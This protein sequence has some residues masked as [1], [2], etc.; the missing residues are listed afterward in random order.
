L[1]VDA[2]LVNALREQL[3]RRAAHASR[4]GWKV[5]AGDSE[6][7]GGELAVG[8]L[9]SATVLEPGSA[10]RGGG[11]DLHADAEVAL[12]LGDGERVSGYGVA[13]ELVDLDQGDDAEGIVAANIFHRAVAFGA[14]REEP[15]RGIHAAVLVNGETRG[16]APVPEDV[17]RRVAAVSR[18]LAAVGEELR[19][20]DRI[21]T[22]S[23]VQVPVRSGDEV[24]A[25]MGALGRVK[26][27]VA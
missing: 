1:S 8:H 2:R 9:T 12:E 4:I 22:G 21:I 13:L 6:R 20:G 26:L 11:A 23:V 27:F 19:A 17:S 24:V 3:S 7:I 10:Y 15:P 14:M 25:D 18:V 16:A 5:G